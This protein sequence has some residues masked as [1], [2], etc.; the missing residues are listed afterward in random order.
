MFTFDNLENVA[1]LFSKS[2]ENQM[3]DRIFSI[4]MSCQKCLTD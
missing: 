1:I 4:L 2:N 3:F